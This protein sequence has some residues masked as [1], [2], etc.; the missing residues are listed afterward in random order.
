MR[1]EMKD[2]FNE[3]DKA[4]KA[5]ELQDKLVIANISSN[6]VSLDSIKVLCEMIETELHQMQSLVMQYVRHI[7]YFTD[8]I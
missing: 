2:I 8:C 3:I 6:V 7:I 5:R 4:S 1:A